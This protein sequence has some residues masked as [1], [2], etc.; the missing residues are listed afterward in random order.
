MAW[1]EIGAWA[2]V[3]SATSLDCA[4]GMAKYYVM[5]GDSTSVAGNGH[6]MTLGVAS[7][8][9]G[10]TLGGLQVA[11]SRQRHCIAPQVQSNL[12]V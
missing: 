12:P 10:M 7:N 11:V 5:Y 6:G 2:A 8:G 4:A 9:Q 1:Y 3:T